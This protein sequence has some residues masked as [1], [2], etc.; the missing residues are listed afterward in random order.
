MRITDPRWP[1]VREL[2]RTVLRE[3]NIVIQGDAWLKSEIHALSM[4][5]SERQP[6]R[7]VFPTFEFKTGPS[8]SIISETNGEVLCICSTEEPDERVVWCPLNARDG[9]PLVRKTLED[10][11]E[12]GY[13][14]CRDCAGPEAEAPWDEHQSRQRMNELE[15]SG[16]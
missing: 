13:P 7:L 2:A 15:N 6:A 1:A 10:L 4:H 8:L 11:I 3:N 9:W 14:G 5:I 12:A 16:A